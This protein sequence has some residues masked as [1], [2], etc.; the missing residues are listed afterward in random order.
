M[1]LTAEQRR[2]R[3]AAFVAVPFCA[4]ILAAGY[5]IVPRYIP[6][7]TAL[8]ERIAF[9]IRVDVFVVLWVFLGVG[10]VAHTRRHSAADIGGA[11]SGPPSR[12]LAVQLAFLQNTL[13]QAVMAVMVHLALATQLSGP[14]LALIIAA[15]LLF[16]IGRVTFLIGYSKGA[17]GRAFGMITTVLPT[18]AGFAL[19]IVLMVAPD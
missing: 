13:E 12:H 6:L 4:A 17:G 19:T 2:I 3:S 11:L 16:G 8:A 10:M 18:L 14:P 1:E 15:V 5:F 9:A 7:P